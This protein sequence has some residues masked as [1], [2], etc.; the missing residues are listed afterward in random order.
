MQE[1]PS[2]TS[3]FEYRRLG[4]PVT[5]HSAGARVDQYLATSYPFLSR[6][7]WQKRIDDYT[8]RVNGRMVKAA[9]RLREGDELTMFAPVRVEPDVDRR[10]K[11]LWQ[12][13]AVMAVF[14]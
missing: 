12:I 3:E 1:P 10:V 9:T 5:P 11:V 8:L 7:G 2:S 14:K 6:A 13:G 4:P